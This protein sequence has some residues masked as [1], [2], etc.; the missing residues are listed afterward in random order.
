MSRELLVCI[1]TACLAAMVS[2]TAADNVTD[3]V[4][5]PDVPVGTR[6][7]S[8]FQCDDD[9]PCTVERCDRGLC[10][11]DPIVCDDN[12]TCTTDSC[13]DGGCV[14]ERTPGCCG[15]DDD[16][17][18]GDPCTKD[19]RC[20]LKTRTCRIAAPIEPCCRSHLDC[21]DGDVC[22]VD[23]CQENLLCSH[24]WDK[25]GSG[26]GICCTLE[27]DCADANRCTRDYCRITDE[28]ASPPTG[29]C[30]RE[31]LCCKRDRDCQ[32]T[33]APCM[34]GVCVIPSGQD[35]GECDY[36]RIPDCCETSSDCVAEPCLSGTCDDGN[37]S[38]DAIPGC[39][40]DD[41]QC[42]DPC[43]FC[44]RGALPSGTCERRTDS[45][46]CEPVVY[47]R[48]FEG[49]FGM[50]VVPMPGPGYSP[51]PE[52]HVS[53]RRSGSGTSSMFFGDEETGLCRGDSSMKTGSRAVTGPIKL[54]MTR[55]PHLR[56]M[57]WKNTDEF[58]RFND[59][60]SVYVRTTGG[61]TKVFSTSQME[62]FNSGDGFVE[63]PPAAESAV[64]LEQWDDQVVQLVFEYDSVVYASAPYEG[65]YIDDIVVSGTCDDRGV[66][67]HD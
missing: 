48:D 28:S 63:F 55:S 12:D 13:A 53:T 40:T 58:S 3:S 10:R 50:E 4:V 62:K 32:Q 22:T 37:C 21:D 2:C 61:E 45:N 59:V 52:W 24:R 7:V 27:T 15:S 6:C 31:I 60:V 42:G 35:D 49:D 66:A 1:W 17:D 56:F 34:Q 57:M 46:C 47:S 29:V 43:L 25:S 51:S 16:C 9:D 14:F 23:T 11:I 54:M 67:L 18:D 36:Q 20:D 33:D 64:S 8:S 38:F 5:E 19:D 30:A 41:E 39:C 26:A 65:I 44:N